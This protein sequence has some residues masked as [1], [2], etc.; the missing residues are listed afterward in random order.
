M[1]N[2]RRRKAPQN[3][4]KVIKF[5]AAPCGALRSLFIYT[6]NERRLERLRLSR[7]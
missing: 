3:P 1:K 5:P 4:R 2:A 7:I 6:P